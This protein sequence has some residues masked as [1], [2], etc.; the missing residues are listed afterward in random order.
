MQ[1]FNQSAIKH[2]LGLLNQAAELG[3]VSKACKMMGL[4]RD[5][6]YRYLES[7]SR[8]GRGGTAR[9]QPAETQSQEPGR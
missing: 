4:A 6:F 9:A 3:S 2:K 7:T 8:R 5:T 1:S